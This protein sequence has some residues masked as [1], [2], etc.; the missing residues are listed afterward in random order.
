MTF[1]IQIF[2]FYCPI[3][4]ISIFFLSISGTKGSEN[5]IRISI[6]FYLSWL[7][8]YSIIAI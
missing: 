6:G 1:L 2:K 4:R 8:V 7:I 5:P 3:S